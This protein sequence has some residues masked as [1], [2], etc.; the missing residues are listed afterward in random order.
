[1]LAGANSVGFTSWSR[2]LRAAVSDLLPIPDSTVTTVVELLGDVG[3]P[4]LQHQAAQSTL[5]LANLLDAEPKFLRVPGVATSVAMRD[6]LLDAT[7]APPVDGVVSEAASRAIDAWLE[8]ELGLRWCEAPAEPAVPAPPPDDPTVIFA[9]ADWLAFW[10]GTTTAGPY[11]WVNDAATGADVLISGVT[12]KFGAM[13]IRKVSEL[14][15]KAQHF[16]PSGVSS[17]QSTIVPA[18]VDNAVGVITSPSGGQVILD[19]GQHTISGLAWSGRGQAGAASPGA[20]APAQ[21][22]PLIQQVLPVSCQ[23]LPIG[24]GRCALLGQTCKGLA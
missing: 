4:A 15:W 2:S 20:A 14:G 5:T 9:A 16:V 19:R 24:F 6:G 8:R 11:T 17:V 3:E 22:L 7:D 10:G 12:G 23:A 1:M 13:A 18:G 21:R